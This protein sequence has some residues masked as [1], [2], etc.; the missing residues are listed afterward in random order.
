M[1]TEAV[2]LNFVDKNWVIFEFVYWLIKF[3]NWWG[4]VKIYWTVNTGIF[5]HC[6]R[7]ESFILGNTFFSAA[8]SDAVSY[9]SSPQLSPVINGV[10]DLESRSWDYET[11]EDFIINPTVRNG[12]SN[13]KLSEQGN[14]PNKSSKKSKR[15]ALP[16]F[17]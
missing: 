13:N 4:Q 2:L 15:N 8:S 1:G 12:D 3:L 17:K 7:C 6:K 16:I 9:E 14:K 11:T 10:T 5:L